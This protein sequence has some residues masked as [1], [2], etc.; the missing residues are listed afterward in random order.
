M[1]I[2]GLIVMTDPVFNKASPVPIFGKPFPYEHPINTDD[3][4][5][6]DVVIISHDH[7]DHLDLKA[8]KDLS[9]TVDR[10]VVPLGIKAHL[11]RW[12]LIKIELASLIGVTMKTTEMLNLP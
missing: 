4:S 9:K 6:V 11:E 1:N 2:D 12:A 7:Y 5:R 3:L 8:I 10:F